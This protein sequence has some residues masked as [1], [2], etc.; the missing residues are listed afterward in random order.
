MFAVLAVVRT[1]R[2]IVMCRARSIVSR[3]R[4]IARSR[5]RRRGRISIMSSR[6]VPVMRRM[7]R[8]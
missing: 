5:V 2:S 6:R 3:V 7:C 8:M 1:V 4:S